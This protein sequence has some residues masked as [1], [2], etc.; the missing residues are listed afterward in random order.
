MEF[1]S[2]DVKCSGGFDAPFGAL[3][4]PHFLVGG[5]TAARSVGCHTRRGNHR[6]TAFTLV[7]LL[8]V[9]AIIGVLVALLLPAIQAAREASRRST[10]QS[11]LH[12]L[13]VAIHSYETANKRLPPGGVWQPD[14][15]VKRG[16]IFVYLLP[17][18]EQNTLFQSLDM[19]RTNVDDQDFAGTNRPVGVTP[20]DVLRCPSDGDDELLN[21]NRAPHNY[22]ASRGPTELWDNPACHCAHEWAALAEAPIDD[23]IEFAGPFTRLGT[24]V[25]LAEVTD[26]TSQTIFLGEVRP[27]C[28]EHA[29]NGWIA[30]NN[31]SGYVSTIIPINFDT[32][33]DTAEDPCHRSCNWN[34]EA[35]FKS[36]HVGGV[37]FL[38]GD[39]SVRFVD[40]TIDHLIYQHLGGK[41]DGQTIDQAI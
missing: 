26:G 38:L 21:P 18:L 1:R 14:S 23:P 39:G 36:T 24:E 19:T 10:C 4:R 40:E 7:E 33:D 29:R 15:K 16:S 20:L 30:S 5:R 22:A 25:R 27:A 17:Y 6:R 12:Q 28:S 34:T 11:N 9:I 41:S 32:C 31:G 8:V 3:D 37:F 2:R 13:G 35:G